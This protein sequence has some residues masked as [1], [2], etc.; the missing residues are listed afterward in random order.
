MQLFYTPRSPYASKVRAVAF[1]KG[2]YDQIELVDVD[3]ANKPK[4]LYKA[5]PLSKIPTLILADGTA[6]YDSPVICEYFDITGKGPKLI[7]DALEE[8]MQVLTLAALAD[9][10]ADAVVARHIE[11][12][13]RSPDKRDEGFYHNQTDKV[14]QGLELLEASAAIVTSDKVT[15]VSLAV[16]STL[17]YI[18]GRAQD[19]GWQR[20]YE[21][22]AAWFQEF[23]HHPSVKATLPVFPAV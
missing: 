22:L 9:G 4:T 11:Y 16:A 15:L 23:Q 20:T 6:I 2:L 7:P 21:K 14:I 3:L 8:R 10:I 18:E 19:L 12:D 1:E 5:N 17:G 13:V